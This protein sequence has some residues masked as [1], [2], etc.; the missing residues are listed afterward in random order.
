MIEPLHTP[1]GRDLSW[2]A[3]LSI[4]SRLASASFARVFL[5]SS[6]GDTLLPPHLANPPHTLCN[7]NEASGAWVVVHF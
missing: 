2:K 1:K 4:V 6:G 7:R 5:A 3:V